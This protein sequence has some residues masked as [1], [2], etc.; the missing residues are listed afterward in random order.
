V[1]VLIDIG[2]PAHVH[3]FR[4][5]AEL[6]RQRGYELMVTS[7]RKEMATDLLDAFGIPHVQLSVMGSAG[8][9]GLIK[10]LCQRDIRLLRVVNRWRPDVM[11]AIGGIFIAHTGLLSRARSLVFYDTENARLQNALTYPFASRVIVPRCYAAWTPRRRTLRYPGYHELSY[12]RP[13]HFNA[14]RTT[15]VANGLR[16]DRPTYLLR[17]VS[18]HAS[19]DLGE[20]GLTWDAVRRV[21]SRLH[22]AAA[23]V[24]ISS[25]AELP[26]DLQPYAYTGDAAQIHHLMAYCTG[27]FGESATMASECAVLGVPAVYAA[28]T[29]RGYTD[30]QE[31]RYGLVKNVRTLDAA[32]LDAGVEW[33]L[34]FA[35]EDARRR[36][37]R[38]LDDTCDVAEFVVRAIETRGEIGAPNGQSG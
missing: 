21:C 4:R 9:F 14:D 38:L 6:L 15:A 12:L 23:H 30:E 29:G 27:F 8:P 10:E 1:R 2:H 28:H 34:G 32:A 24:V 13:P 26:T 7:R 35:V 37:Q 5:P 11:A 18:W 3:F 31:M 33:L 22:A 16:S 19:H 36:R 25:E 20:R 17:L